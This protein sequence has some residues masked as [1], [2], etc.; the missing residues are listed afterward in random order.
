[1]RTKLDRSPWAFP[2]FGSIAILA[3]ACFVQL[4][5]PDVMPAPGA[6]SADRPSA[7]ARR[8]HIVSQPIP[9]ALSRLPVI[10]PVLTYSTFLGGTNSSGPGGPQQQA[11]A[12]FVDGPGNVYVTGPT[13][14]P[15]FPIT[16]G[17]VQTTNPSGASISFLTKI[18]PAGT[19]L[20]FSTYLNL[21]DA[22]VLAVDASGNVFV[23][24]TNLSFPIPSGTTPFQATAKTGNSILIVKLNSTATSVLDATYLGGSGEDFLSGLAVDADGNLYVSGSTTSN[25]FPTK[26]P[27]QASLGTSGNSNFVAKLDPTLSTLLYSTY[28]GQD[29]GGLDLLAVDASKNA[30]VV[31]QASSGFPVTSGALQATCGSGSQCGTLAK[32]NPSASGSASLLYGTYL[33]G[34]SVLTQPAAVAVD[35]SQNVYIS[36]GTNSGFPLVNSLQA[37]SPITGNGF[38]AEV[39]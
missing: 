34:A 33:G 18:N 16:P 9:S 1:M 35:S 2:L 27:Y 15:D 11:Y 23:G 26:N 39:K 13:N 29:S 3:I 7:K 4:T 30:Y 10:D 38:V 24:G 31:G 20:V 22:P 14:A 25:D 28:L 5:D 37:C 19:S 6:A 36:G 17:T 12:S 21:T 32:L 8:G